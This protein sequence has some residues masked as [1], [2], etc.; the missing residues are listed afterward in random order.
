L[1]SG[2]NILENQVKEFEKDFASYTGS[3]YCTGVASGPDALILALEALHL[4]VG[5][6]VLV[7]SNKYITTLIAIVQNG[8]RPVPL[9]FLLIKYCILKR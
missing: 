3:R 5:S 7:P 2:W 8:F 4:D 6:E 9:W 1:E